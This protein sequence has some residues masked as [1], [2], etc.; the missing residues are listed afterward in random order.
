MVAIIQENALRAGAGSGVGELLA[1]QGQR[2]P[3]LQLGIPDG[4]IENGTREACLAM[5]GLDAAGLTVR[6]ESAG[7]MPSGGSCGSPVVS[8]RVSTSQ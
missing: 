8:V 5:L 1:T 7:G 3:L 6:I 4:V 2:I